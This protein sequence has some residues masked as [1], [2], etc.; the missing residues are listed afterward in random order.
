MLFGQDGRGIGL[1]RSDDSSGPS[2]AWVSAARVVTRINDSLGGVAGDNHIRQWIAKKQTD[3]Q[4]QPRPQAT[5]TIR[6]LDHGWVFI[7][8]VASGM[9]GHERPFIP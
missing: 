9:L 2:E 8:G 7:L 5:H 6:P 3:R 4:H 1:A